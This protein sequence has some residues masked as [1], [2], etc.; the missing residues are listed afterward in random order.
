MVDLDLG[1]DISHEEWR[2][3]V[4]AKDGAFIN[5]KIITPMMLY[6][7]KTEKGEAH[8]IVSKDGVTH[9]IPAG[10]ISIRWKHGQA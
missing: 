4:I 7:I 10:W 1:V 6:V 2:E 3:Y 8:Q 5:M 9:Y